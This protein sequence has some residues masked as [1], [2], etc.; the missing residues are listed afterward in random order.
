MKFGQWISAPSL[1]R[2]IL[3]GLTG[4]LSLPALGCDTVA[5]ISFQE[6]N[7]ARVDTSGVTPP[8]ASCGGSD[9]D[10]IMRFVLVGDDD[11]AIRPGDTVGQTP[12]DLQTDDLTLTNGGVF[13]FPDQLCADNSECTSNYTCSL[14]EPNYD[15]TLQ[16]CL[17]SAELG[18]SGSLSFV[19]DVEGNQ[20]FG[21]VVENAGSLEGWLPRDVGDKY[22]DWNGDG[23]ADG[24]LDVNL[25]SERGTDS[26]NTRTPAYSA[27]RAQWDFVRIRALSEGDRRSLFG[28]WYFGGTSTGAGVT[29]AI[30][31]ATGDENTFWASQPGT[32]DNAI[33][34]IPDAEQ[35]RANVYQAMIKALEDGFA[36]PTLADYEKTMVV[37]VDGPDDLRLQNFN[38][39][40][41][42]ELANENDVRIFIAHLDAQ[43]QLCPN[44]D[45]ATG[46]CTA[47]EPLLI[48]DDPDYWGNQ[49][50]PCTDDSECFNY[51]ECRVPTGYSST[52]GGAVEIGTSETYCMPKRDTR[53][54]HGAIDEYARI[55]CETEGGYI[56]M[57][58]SG[59]PSQVIRRRMSWL[60]QTLDGLWEVETTLD[61]I[62]NG[63][64]AAGEPVKIQ[65]NFSVN[66][67][68]TTQTIALSQQGDAS[69]GR[70]EDDQDTRVVLFAE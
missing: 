37:F 20:L 34:Q 45:A 35:D 66:V 25:R 36:D 5:L 50:G 33:D 62:E 26:D 56:H 21:L 52:P 14:A 18:I 4:V 65:S 31:E 2:T 44:P 41:V 38:A 48:R 42:I 12:V 61:V 70:Q 69:A 23:T 13:E 9:G 54:R 64:V 30:A 24:E 29:S 1:T 10:A 28:L 16:R 60:P 8:V 19:S 47:G 58:S 68:Q 7:F 63:Q 49:V 40:R 57:K 6:R 46:E 39:D 27:I 22:P 55:A 59:Q 51:E 17:N 43:I 11:T 15:G 3:M 67:S 32:V 53:G